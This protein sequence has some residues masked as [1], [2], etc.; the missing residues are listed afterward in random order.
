MHTCLRVFLYPAQ[1]YD[2]TCI[3]LQASSD[4]ITA[5]DD[6]QSIRADRDAL[7]QG[8][9]RNAAALPAVRT[10]PRRP[11]RARSFRGQLGRSQASDRPSATDDMVMA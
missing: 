7:Q 2:A 9:V 10:Q 6:N 5:A 11:G 8:A 1:A 4:D 3:L